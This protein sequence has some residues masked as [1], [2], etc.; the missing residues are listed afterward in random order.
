[1]V[2]GPPGPDGPAGR[3]GIDGAKGDEGRR[4]RD[5]VGV[6]ATAINRRGELLVTHTDGTVHTPGRVV[7]DEKKRT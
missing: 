7:A 5:G 6:A 1:M 3:D 4:G 2:S